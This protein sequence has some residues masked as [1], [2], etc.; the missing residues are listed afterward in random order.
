MW[1]YNVYCL[2]ALDQTLR[3]QFDTI[4]ECRAF[5]RNSGH[6]IEASIWRNKDGAMTHFFR[7]VNGKWAQD[8]A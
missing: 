2:F 5:I 4:A 1:K 3:G 7:K 6:A 8:N